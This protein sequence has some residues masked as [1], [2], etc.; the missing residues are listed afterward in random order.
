[1]SMAQMAVDWHWGEVHGVEMD[2]MTGDNKDT[3]CHADVYDS[4]WQQELMGRYT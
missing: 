1:M 2:L 3:P 4:R